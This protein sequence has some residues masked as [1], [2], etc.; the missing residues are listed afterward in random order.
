MFEFI[1][2]SLLDIV[3]L[4]RLHGVALAILLEADYL[5]V[6]ELAAVVNE[7]VLAD[8][9]YHKVYTTLEDLR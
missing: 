2:D 9:F 7:K 3:L 4:S 1:V 5:F 8:F 6:D